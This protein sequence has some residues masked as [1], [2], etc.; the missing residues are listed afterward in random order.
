MVLRSLSTGVTGLRAESDALS[1]NADN[2]A[3]VNTVGFKSQR[4]IFADQLG[5][6]I[7][8]G[9]TSNNP[10]SG[11]R[12]TDVQVMHKQGTLSNTG[13]STDLALSGDGFFTLSGTVDGVTSNFYSRN[14]QFQLDRDG[15]MVNATGLNVMGYA[16]AADG[17]FEASLSEIQVPTAAIPPKVTENITL[18]ANLDSNATEPADATGT[19]IPW[20]P[21]DPS[22]TSNF[23]TSITVYDSLGNGHSLDVYFRKTAT[24]NT[25]EYHVVASGSEMD[26]PVAGNL[27]VGDGTLAFTDTGALDTFT[28][29]TPIAL[30]FMN[31]TPGQTITLDL[32]S[33]VSTGGTGL[34]G[35]TQFA[36]KD[37]ISSQSQDGYTSGEFAGVS[38]DGEGVVRGLYTN[39]EKLAIAQLG[40]AKF[41]SNEGLGRAGSQLFM[42][43]RDSGEAAMGVAGSGGRAAVS[44]GTLEMSNVDLAEEFVGLIQHQRAYSA[45]S[46]V[47]TTADDML[48]ELLNIK[49]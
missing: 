32:G 15:F 7:L 9:T 19:V 45:N 41:T 6:S 23:S 42:Q 17:T 25:Y 46:K 14:G 1:V 36:G 4:A 5:R 33:Q 8:A 22:R 29:N 44:S 12:V 16:A 35:I 39:G 27:E 10:G 13:I 30:N 20:D 48:Q 26:P 31:A 24:A 3:N 49:R 2:I 34:D 28:E 21:Q 38:V 11:V 18:V 40:I 47:I 43:T 37:N